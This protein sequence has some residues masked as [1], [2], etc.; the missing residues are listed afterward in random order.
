[1][2]FEGMDVAEVDSIGHQ[3]QGQADEIEKVI[4]RINGLVAQ[5][6]GVWHGKDAQDFEGWWHNQHQPALRAAHDAIHG[7]GQSAINN[8]RDQ[9]AASGR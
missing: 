8:A 9:Q 7:L 5:L 3:L 6:Q 1:M 2:P 4:G